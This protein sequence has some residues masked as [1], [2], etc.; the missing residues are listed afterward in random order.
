[1]S[2][3]ICFSVVYICTAFF[4]LAANTK[5]F[6]NVGHLKICR[7]PFALQLINDFEI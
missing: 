6:V 7:F 4:I 5:R 1:M 2:H 3:N